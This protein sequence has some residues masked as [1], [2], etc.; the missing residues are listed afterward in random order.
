M[1]KENFFEAEKITFDPNSVFDLIL[2][3]FSHQSRRQNVEIELCIVQNLTWSDLSK[4]LDA[5]TDCR[6]PELVGDQRRL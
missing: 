1:F 2:E 6:L 3:I 4:T 5:K